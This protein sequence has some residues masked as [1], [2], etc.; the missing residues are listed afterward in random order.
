M[1]QET[2]TV[3]G[4]D[5][6]GTEIPNGA[7][8]HSEIGP[9][10]VLGVT[11]THYRLGDEG[12]LYV[13]E[14]GA[15]FTDCLFP[16]N[17]WL[18]KKWFRSNSQRLVGTSNVYR[19]TTK[20][21]DG[22]Q[23]EIVLKWNRMGQEIPGDEFVDA[24]FNSPFEE[25]S[26]VSDLKEAQKQAGSK[27]I[28]QRPLAIY[29]PPT[30]MELWRTGRKAYRMENVI[31]KHVE[32]ELDM[33]R[34][35]AVI[36][37]WIK[38]VD[39]DEAH[40]SGLITETE[41]V[42]LTREV[43][44]HIQSQGFDVLDRKPHHVILRPLKQGGVLRDKAGDARHALVDFELLR[45][46]AQRETEVLQGKR[47]NYLRRQRDRFLIET[48]KVLPSH[49]H[50]MNIL[51]VGYIYGRTESTNGALWVVGKDPDLFDYFLP[52]RWEKSPRTRLSSVHEVF[53]T[54]TK[55]N[56]NLTW[57]VSKVGI[58]PN[59]DPIQEG[60][61]AILDFGYNSP[62]E[63]F[64]LAVKLSRAGIPTIYPRA[65]Y[66]T[67]SRTQISDY[68]FDARRFETHEN[69]LTQDDEPVLK[70]D[71]DYITIWGYW[72]GPDEKLAAR[73][74]DHL[75]GVNALRAWR[76]GLISEPE[77]VRLME[78]IRES[79]R[80]VQVVD[81]NLRGTH[82]LLSRRTGTGKL[83]LD[84]D[85]YPEFRICTFELLSGP[86]NAAGVAEAP[87]HVD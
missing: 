71:R 30:R 43:H 87:P 27:V 2:P 76:E 74:E 32:I 31:D 4:A 37:E 29:V 84:S 41:M 17:H 45:F 50:Y 46:T 39:A 6:A 59:A 55:D 22:R 52:E 82:I 62:F 25:F 54:R 81:L 69:V 15:P 11:Y 67:G 34:L 47:S 42:S 63:E 19:V 57:K 53:Y 65:I 28:L 68:L 73:D 3:S 10:R 7:G 48:P 70:S 44:E 21:V 16:E 77:Y 56:I 33:E 83:V 40:T 66:M 58:L 79:L 9:V 85:G 24:E 18:D 61:R 1:N 38:G 36:Y 35:Y 14:E 49:L 12:D 8:V 80:A 13:T 5:A 23:R 75:E 64:A 72:N 86:L 60:E 20:P 78:R 51:G 26:L